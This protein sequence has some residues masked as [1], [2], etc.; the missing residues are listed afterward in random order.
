[1]LAGLAKK[2]GVEVSTIMDMLGPFFKELGIKLGDATSAG[3]EAYKD[4]LNTAADAGFRKGPKGAFDERDNEGKITYDKSDYSKFIRELKIAVYQNIRQALIQAFIESVMTQGV[5]GLMMAKI[6]GLIDRYIE[7]S[8]ERRDAILQK[9]INRSKVIA[10]AFK[11]L[12]PIFKEW[13]KVFEQLA[14]IFAVPMEELKDT[15]D[16]VFYHFCNKCFC[17]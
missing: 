4:A 14:D 16:N 1:M 10:A 11:D 6:L 12:E 9:I 2:F 5:I 3:V 15:N 7:A 13:S 17:K 8:A